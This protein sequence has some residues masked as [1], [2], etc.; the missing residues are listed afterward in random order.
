MVAAYVCLGCNYFSF[1]TLD[2]ELARVPVGF[3]SASTNSLSSDH[4]S[5]IYECLDNNTIAFKEWDN[6]YYCQGTPDIITY[7]NNS[8]Q[9]HCNV[10]DN[11]QCSYSY[12]N[13]SFYDNVKNGCDDNSKFV[14]WTTWTSFVDECVYK[15]KVICTSSSYSVLQYESTNCRILTSNQTS[16]AGCNVAPN[17]GRNTSHALFYDIINC[18]TDQNKHGISS[19][20]SISTSDTSNS[21]VRSKYLSLCLFLFCIIAN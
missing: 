2:I 14:H 11:E 10:N 1:V 6:S 3:C 17:Q 18:D 21:G 19:T 13:V 20:I 7:Y 8:N 5:S 4:G 12:V 16:N 15:R 9:V